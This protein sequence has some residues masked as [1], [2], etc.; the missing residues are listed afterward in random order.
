LNPL[1]GETVEEFTRVNGN[2]FSLDVSQDGTIVG[3]GDSQ[4]SL[5]FDNINYQF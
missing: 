1:T 2:C 3:F 5:H 4:G